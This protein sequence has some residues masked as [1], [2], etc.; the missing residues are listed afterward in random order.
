MFEV[1]DLASLYFLTG[2]LQ[3]GN[4]YLT[5]QDMKVSKN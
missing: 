4:L 3:K 1:I 2:V 5:I